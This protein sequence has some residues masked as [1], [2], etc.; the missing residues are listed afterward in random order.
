MKTTLEIDLDVAT[1]K[2]VSKALLAMADACDAASEK[3]SCARSELSGA[4]GDSNA[5]LVWDHLAKRM[6]GAAGLLRKQ[7]AACERNIAQYV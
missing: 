7:A 2:E 4:W 6:S 1:P 3:Y 5:G